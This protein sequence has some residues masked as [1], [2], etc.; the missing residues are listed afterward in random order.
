[1]Y[2]NIQCSPVL[3]VRHHVPGEHGS[4]YPCSRGTWRKVRHTMCLHQFF[5]LPAILGG[6]ICILCCCVMDD[7]TNLLQI[8]F[9]I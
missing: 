1:M 6:S 8:Y 2:K 7:D 9:M 5:G 4:P 3:S